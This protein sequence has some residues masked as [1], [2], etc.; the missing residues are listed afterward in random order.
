MADTSS[1]WSFEPA[2][3]A[4]LVED[5]NEPIAPFIDRLHHSDANER[6]AAAGQLRSN[7]RARS[8]DPTIVNAL[9]S[10]LPLLDDPDFG[11]VREV[12]ATV[13]TISYL[14]A[15]QEALVKADIT[16]KVVRLLGDQDHTT[17][18]HAIVIVH[19]TAGHNDKGRNGYVKAGVIP[20]LQRL[21]VSEDT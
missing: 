15:G 6:R 19:A 17:R 2:P 21:L 14:P 5:P 8:D 18:D 20:A 9:P 11:V 10:L 7:I 12:I 4:N 16:S 1:H 13:R 3:P